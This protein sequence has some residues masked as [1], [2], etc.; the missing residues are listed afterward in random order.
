MRMTTESRSGLRVRHAMLVSIVLLAST[1]LLAG[2]ASVPGDSAPT[3]VGSK[4]RGA[5][6]SDSYLCGDHQFPAAAIEEPTRIADLDAAARAAIAGATDDIGK[7]VAPDDPKGWIVVSEDA[8]QISL[9]RPKRDQD[10]VNVFIPG[11]AESDYEELTLIY[12]ASEGGWKFASNGRC[13]LSFDLGELQVPELS[14]DPEHAPDADARELRFLVLDPTC[15]GD[16]D[17]PQRIEVVR[18]DETS[19]EV[20]VVLG[21]RPLPPG[22]YHCPGFPPTPYA[23]AL[24][25]PLGERTVVDASRVDPYRL[26]LMEPQVES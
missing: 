15:G 21:V 20:R 23:V 7:S 24:R 1:V 9:I 16:T 26:P 3:N 6:I 11:A 12:V 8:E 4:T 14:L 10:S 22:A 5:A 25:E 2:C 19:T 17:M 13:R 18:V